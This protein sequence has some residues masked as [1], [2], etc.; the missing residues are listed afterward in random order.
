MREPDDKLS[1]DL[2]ALGDTS[3]AVAESLT[4]AGIRGR[5]GRPGSCPISQYLAS[6][7]YGDPFV[8]QSQIDTLTEDGG[9]QWVTT[10]VPV[11]TFIFEFDKGQHSHL[12]D[13]NTEYANRGQ[14]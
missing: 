6:K 9:C 10:P 11:A 14:A 7:G 12:R 3:A 2:A 13:I 4:K 1:R 8:T 5:R